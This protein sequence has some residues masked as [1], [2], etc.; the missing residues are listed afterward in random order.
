[1]IVLRNLDLVISDTRETTYISIFPFKEKAICLTIKI[2]L[3]DLI[4]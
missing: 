1:M 4:F 3:V 2:L